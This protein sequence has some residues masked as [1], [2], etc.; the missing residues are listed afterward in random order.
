MSSFYTDANAVWP[1]PYLFYKSHYVFIPNPWL[2]TS[3]SD[4]VSS[5]PLITRAASNSLIQTQKPHAVFS[6]LLPLLT[7]RQKAGRVRN[8]RWERLV[9]LFGRSAFLPFCKVKANDE[10]GNNVIFLPVIS[11][12]TVTLLQISAPD[13][14]CIISWHYGNTR[15]AV[16]SPD[17]SLYNTLGVY[18]WCAIFSLS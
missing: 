3:L 15:R 14:R 7:L 18:C 2:E 4:T 12:A 6:C 5:L 13:N 16:Y 8:R 1:I 17:F 10:G 9:L 11:V